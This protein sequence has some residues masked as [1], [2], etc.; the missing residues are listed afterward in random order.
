MGLVSDKAGDKK[1]IF[2]KTA[3]ILSPI[4]LLVTLISYLGSSVFGVFGY[5]ND[6][7]KDIDSLVTF[8]QEFST[9]FKENAKN[10]DKSIDTL[11]SRLDYS[12][13]RVKEL[14]N[15]LERLS[16]RV[17]NSESKINSMLE[18]IKEIQIALNNQTIMVTQQSGDIRV[19][20]EIMQRV[21]KGNK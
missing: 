10:Y 14:N 18:V 9:H 8:K 12:E 5:S 6:L 13:D 19:I 2:E 17:S 1:T 15:N 20:R 21:E 4:L 16:D 3:I 7:R 11:D